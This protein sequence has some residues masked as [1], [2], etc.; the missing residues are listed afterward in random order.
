[1][2][3][4]KWQNPDWWRWN[5]AATRLHLSNMFA[6]IKSNPVGSVNV[7]KWYDNKPVPRRSDPEVD[8]LTI[9]KVVWVFVAIGAIG[10]ALA[11]APMVA[12]QLK[13]VDGEQKGVRAESGP[14]VDLL[15]RPNPIE[16]MP[17]LSWRLVLSMLTGNGY[18]VEDDSDSYLWHVNPKLVTPIASTKGI[19]GYQIEWAGERKVLKPEQI[20]HFKW[21]CAASEWEG[22]SLIEPVKGDILLNLYYK[23]YMAG[24]FRDGA[25]PSGVL[26]SAALLK[27][28]DVDRIR[29]RWMRQHSGVDKSHRLAVLDKSTNYQQISPPIKE[30]IAE[31]LYTMPRDAILAA[32]GVTPVM[33]GIMDEASYNTA[34]EQKQI[35]WENTV[36]PFQQIIA[37]T[38]NHQYVGRHFGDRVRVE[39]DNSNVKPLQEDENR[40][41][42]REAIYVNTGIRPI[43][44]VR[45]EHGWEPIEGGDE[46]LPFMRA[47]IQAL[48]AA[49]LNNQTDRD[50]AASE[51]G[52]TDAAKSLVMPTWPSTSPALVGVVKKTD[53]PRRKRWEF[54][55]KRVTRGQREF[56]AIMRRY[57][58]AQ[59]DRVISRL[60]G[61]AIGREVNL[62]LLYSAMVA[63]AE[64]DDAI[65]R[66][67]E[68]NALLHESVDDY[69]KD[70]IKRAGTDAIDNVPGVGLVFDI[71]NPQVDI[72]I[73]EFRN[74][75]ETI[76]DTTYDAIKGVLWEVYDEGM[77]LREAERMLVDQVGGMSRTRARRIAATEMNGMVNGGEMAGYIQA[78][79]DQKEWQSAFLPTSRETHKAA[80]GQ[81][82]PMTGKFLV[83]GEFLEYP[84]D[85]G[86]SA[87]NVVNCYCVIAPVV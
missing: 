2:A 5:L 18:L 42:E 82:I 75:I 80:N 32:L 71:R 37:S 49:S 63:K 6:A 73:A 74:R 29:D 51:N 44:E 1:L 10:K 36:L 62:A 86:G 12:M 57:L 81:I 77:S 24:F 56:E 9:D 16:S 50:N 55:Y 65:F 87:G 38:F 68:E 31:L 13:V 40:R 85:P 45:A 11:S 3:K 69:M 58:D 66:I 30:I 47:R 83:D 28:E 41:A 52:A 22:A 20:L 7:E 15:A 25:V 61:V 8:L 33:A 35:F 64:D 34:S 43:N 72:M 67:G 84:G 46:P 48:A 54:H 21:P 59:L 70:T 27:D 14:L 23:R 19:T 53:D 17:I 76:N 26:S 78:G 79:I 4:R 60:N 39:F